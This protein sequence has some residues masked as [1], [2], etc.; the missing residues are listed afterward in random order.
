MGPGANDAS[1]QFWAELP[2]GLE[3]LWRSYVG[4]KEVLERSDLGQVKMRKVQTLMW[5]YM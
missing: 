5:V 3:V 2:Q 4:L 1:G